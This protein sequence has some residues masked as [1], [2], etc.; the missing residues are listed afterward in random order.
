MIGLQHSPKDVFA[1][2]HKKSGY[3]VYTSWFY[4]DFLELT[5]DT[6]KKVLIERDSHHEVEYDDNDLMSNPPITT[7]KQDVV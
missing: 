2:N 5:A 7:T 4:H 6:K 3:I 1:H